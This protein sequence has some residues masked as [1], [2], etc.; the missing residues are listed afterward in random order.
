MERGSSMFKIGFIGFGNMA[1]A[2]LGGML[3]GGLVQRSEVAC[4]DVTDEATEKSAQM[5]GIH[6]CSSNAEL[7]R[8]S[9][10][11][12]LSVKPQ[13]YAQVIAEIAPEVETQTV[14]TIAPGKQLSWLQEQFGKAVPIVRCMPNTP[15]LVGEGCTA[16]CRN[17]LVSD[18]TFRHVLRL[19][20]SVGT[21]HELEERHFD[22]FVGISGSSPA[23][24]Y[25]FIEALA[26]AAVLE[27]IPRQQAYQFAAQAVL[28]SAKMVLDTGKH[29]GVLKDAVC[30]PA[31]TTIEAVRVL[32]EEGFRAAVMHAV[33]ACAEKSRS[34]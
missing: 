12:V 6:A 16:V 11:I 25:I 10:L 32:E 8:Q 20:G 26:D 9:E 22:A 31:G 1:S 30:S 21:A 7:A 33:S 5:L 13:F 34:L 29:P 28:G 2:M 4:R 14:L 24:V 17:E 18:E 19:L 3:H 27:G 15:A 23:Y